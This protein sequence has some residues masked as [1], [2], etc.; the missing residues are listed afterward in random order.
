MV[1]RASRASSS[2]WPTR[3]S[4]WSAT[5]SSAAR[6][7]AR[8]RRADMVHAENGTAIDMLVERALAAGET[9]PINHASRAPRSSR[10]R[11]PAAPRAWPSGGRLAVR[12]PRDVRGGGRGDRG[13]PAARRARQ[14]RDLRAVPR[15]HDRRPAP[16]GRRG[17]RYI[18]SPPLR[19]AANHEPLWDYV[20]RGSARERLDRPLPVQ[21]RAEGARPR[22]LQPR[23]QRPAGH[24]APPREALG[25]G[26]RRRAH[27]AESSSTT[28][29]TIAR[30]FGLT[31]KGAIAPGK[32]ADIVV[33]D[34][35]RR[36]PYDS[37]IAH[38]RRLRPLR[39]RDGERQRASH[40]VPRH[41]GLRPRR[42]P[43]RARPRPLRRR[44]R[45]RAP[46]WPHA[47]RD[48]RRPR[49][50]RPARAARALR[51]PRRRPPRALD[52]GV[53]QGARARAL[54]SSTSCR[55]RSTATRPAT[56]GPTSRASRTASSSSAR[57]STRCPAGGWLDG[58]SA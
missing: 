26:R 24:P 33:F 2:S 40:V 34:P 53:A 54:A 36:E 27:H 32:D 5:T 8:P 42:D 20:R 29:T 19:D 18:C 43:H 47:P 11:R 12:R 50:R 35:T 1:E 6:E 38:E 57:T 28:S 39:G 56:S 3:A 45:W 23:A 17:R 31:K 37:H 10:R 13:R 51:R 15:Q 21:R 25:R 30:R 9:D 46:R 7:R 55:S 58:A 22:Q 49:P 44:G 16:A 52:R 48:R 14:R 4:S 41:A